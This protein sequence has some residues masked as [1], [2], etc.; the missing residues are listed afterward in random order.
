[1]TTSPPDRSR[2]ATLTEAGIAAYRAGQQE[3]ARVLLAEAT[4]ADHSYELAWLWRTQVAATPD[5]QRACLEQILRLNPEHWQARTLLERLGPPAATPAQP[6]AQLAPA[7][8][9]ALTAG[10]SVQTLEARSS[11]A[12]E[13]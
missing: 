9:T 2:A 11:A 3:Q 8:Y 12:V 10:G 4:L 7:R 13:T 6:E 5:E 1:M